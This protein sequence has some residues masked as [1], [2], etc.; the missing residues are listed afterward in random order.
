MTEM[1]AR[2]QT[3]VFL[4]VL[5][6]M[7]LAASAL[8]AEELPPEPRTLVLPDTQLIAALVG[9]FA[10]AV[11]YVINRWAPWV[12]EPIKGVVFIV[13]AA[14]GGALTTLLDTGGIPINLQT[15]QVIG[16]SVVLALL[17]HLGFWKPSGL[18]AMFGAGRNERG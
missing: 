4:S 7:L 11:A 16:T 2:I 10:P 6:L 3:A 17:A 15:L 9:A 14:I 1:R 12:R 8:A 13:V 5:G 18:G